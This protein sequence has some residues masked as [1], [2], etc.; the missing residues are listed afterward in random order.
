MKTILIYPLLL[1][2]LCFGCQPTDLSPVEQKRK[3][4]KEKKKEFNTLKGEIATLESEILELDPPKE[5]PRKLVTTKVLVAQDFERFAEVQGSVVSDDIVFATSET[6]G[7]LTNVTPSEGEFVTRGQVV[8]SVDMEGITKQKAEIESAL[9]LSRDVFNRQKRL[10]DQKIGT[11]VQFLQAKNAVDRLE[12]SMETLNFQMTKSS[13]FAPISG[14]VEK[15]F[16][17]T[18]EMS[19][20]GSPILQILNTSKI[21]VKVDVPERYLKSVKRGQVVK[22][23]FPAIEVE[24]NAKISRIAPTINPGNRTFEVVINLNNPSGL[25]KPNLLASVFFKDF[26]KKNVVLVPLEIIQQEISGGSYVYIKTE[27]QNG[28]VSKKVMVETGESDKGDVI[29]TEGLKGG[30]ELI[31]NGAL[32][33]GDEELIMVEDS[34]ISTNG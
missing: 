20:P 30:E 4:L 1:L 27:G 17:K 12:K 34:K 6:G 2:T 19:A 5:K 23:E 25:L 18:G 22:V 21:K 29:I 8:A 32:G 24:K 7:R 3:D 16:L 33:L 13:V 14:V 31:L 9:E 10:W 15:V 11:E 26:E 28:A